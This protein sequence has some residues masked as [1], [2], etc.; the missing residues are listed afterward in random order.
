MRFSGLMS[1]WYTPREWQN[2]TPAKNNRRYN[3]IPSVHCPQHIAQA[4]ENSSIMRMHRAALGRPQRIRTKLATQAG[5][6]WGNGPSVACL[7]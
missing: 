2:A 5:S 7:R 3:G 1:R 6:A 4:R